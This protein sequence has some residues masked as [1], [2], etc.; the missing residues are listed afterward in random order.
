MS[1]SASILFILAAWL[2]VATQVKRWH[3]L[4]HS[5][6]LV[7][8]NLSIIAAPILFVVLGV[9]R[10]DDGPNK[11]GVRNARSRD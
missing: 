10:G 4:D 7:L 8:Y 6:A 11:Y 2:S 9:C 3:D 1:L 5:G